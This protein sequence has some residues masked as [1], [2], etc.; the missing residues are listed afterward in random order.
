M[1]AQPKKDQQSYVYGPVPSRRLGRSLGVDLVP[2]KTCSYDCIYCQLGRTTPKSIDVCV[3]APVDV[4]V[5]QV[6][7]RLY[8]A[9][10]I[11]TLA[12]SGEPTLFADL[13]LL[14]QRIKEITCVPVAVITNGSLLWKPEVRQSLPQADLVIPSLDAGT[15]PRFQYVNRPHAEIT[16]EKMVDGLIQFRQEFTGDYWLEVLLLA[17]VT[18]V[19]VEVQ[20]LADGI[21]R[22]EPDRIQVNTV[23]R[24]P[25]EGFAEAV[26][27]GQ[28]E[29][30]ARQLYDKVEVIADF[31][32][33]R[34]D[35][36]RGSVRA[37]EILALLER[38]PCSLQDIVAG[39]GLHHQAAIK[40]MTQLTHDGHVEVKPQNGNL[41]YA[42]SRE[43]WI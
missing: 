5:E 7:E 43:Q 40:E 32:P 30:I 2:F 1:I 20:A 8:L 31:V 39:L 29:A 15:A 27:A 26:P 18:T 35:R 9:P 33:S 3:Q 41:F 14:I 24:P 6:R 19:T 23:A 4:I 11:I 22:I 13:G 12:G 34:N 28:L 21:R 10:D 16:F 37:E 38:R 36:G 25:C 42:L 17:G